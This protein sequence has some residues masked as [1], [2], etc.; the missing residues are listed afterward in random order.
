MRCRPLVEVVLDEPAAGDQG[1]ILAARAAHHIAPA[2]VGHRAS[3]GHRACKDPVDAW[4]LILPHAQKSRP[5]T[6]VMARLC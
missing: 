4:M 3:V 5:D 6:Q 2:K 1:A